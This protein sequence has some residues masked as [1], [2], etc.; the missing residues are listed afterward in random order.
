[1]AYRERTGEGQHVEGSM[2]E[3][4]AG[5]IGEEIL[6]ANLTAENPPRAGNSDR[7]Y[8]PHGVFPIIGNR[9]REGS[10]LV[11][12]H[13]TL[14]HQSDGWLA[15]SITNDEEW[16]W[17]VELAGPSVL[18][19]ERFATVAGRLAHVAELEERLAAW[20]RTEDGYNLMRRLQ[21][22]GVPAGVVQNYRAV[23]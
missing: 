15:I 3:T 6:F 10:A 14:E 21:A 22:A 18:R 8:A 4:C 23:L 13:A 19:D 12:Q 5:Y 16:E 11:T 17:L 20:T 9:D 2:L 1:L 7:Q